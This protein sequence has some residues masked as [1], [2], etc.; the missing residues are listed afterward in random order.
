MRWSAE[1]SDV[2]GIGV[3][4]R[5]PRNWG[6]WTFAGVVSVLLTLGLLNV[7]GARP[8]TSRV[9]AGEVTLEVTAPTR[10]RGG[11]LFEGR[12][13]IRARRALAEPVLVLERGWGRGITINTLEPAPAE[14]DGRH[15]RLAFTFAPLAAGESLEVQMDFQVNP[16]G[17]WRAPQ[18]VSLRDGDRTIATLRRTVTVFP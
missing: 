12:F 5:A 8:S 14:E 4:D 6:R 15:G 13:T 10:L 11:L 17:A 7:F 9:D 1:L 3:H 2:T 16:T 18:G